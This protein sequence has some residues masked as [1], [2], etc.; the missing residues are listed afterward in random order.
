LVSTGVEVDAVVVVDVV[1]DVEVEDDVEVD[2]VA[3][4]ASPLPL[5]SLMVPLARM[6]AVN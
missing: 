6:R 3:T 4:I 5:M 2:G 1:V